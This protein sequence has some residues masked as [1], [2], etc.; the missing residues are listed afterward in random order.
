[1]LRLTSLASVCLPLRTMSTARLTAATS[2]AAAVMIVVAG[3]GI[4]LGWASAAAVVVCLGASKPSSFGVCACSAAPDAALA[5][6][7]AG[8]RGTALP[9]DAAGLAAVLA[10]VLAA[11][12]AGG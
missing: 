8:G 12:L 1:M 4:E 10:A 6:G 11:G 9:P 5:P 7:R 2:I 3:G